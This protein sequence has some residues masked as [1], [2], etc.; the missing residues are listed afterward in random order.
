MYLLKPPYIKTEENLVNDFDAWITMAVA[1]DYVIKRGSLVE[2]EDI[3]ANWGTE[4]D[5]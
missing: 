4:V 2:K 5:Q 1:C 3:F